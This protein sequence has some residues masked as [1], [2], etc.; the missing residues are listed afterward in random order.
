MLLIFFIG[1][2]T[3]YASFVTFKRP[4]LRKSSVGIH[5]L[6]L[7]LIS[8]Y[9]LF[10]LIMKMILILF[11]SLMNDITCKIISYMLSVSIRCSFWLTS[12]IAIQRVCYVLF[13]FT[14]LLKNPRLA[15]II[16]FT[17]LLIVAGMHVHELI[18]YMKDPSGQTA[19]VVNFPLKV[20][21]YDRI[22]VLLHYIIPFCIQIL[23]ITVL[24][25]LAARS[26]SRTT[27]NRDAFIKYLERQFQSQKELYIVP[28]VIIFS[29][30]PQ[31]ILSFSFACIQLNTWQQHALLIAYL[32]SYAPQLLGFIL[33]VLPSTNYIKEFQATNLSK[34]IIFRWIYLRKTTRQ[35][36][37]TT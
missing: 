36:K 17:T 23:S 24:I 29:G 20:I 12:W 14:T 2:V 21:T 33:F 7:S 26:R 37:T 28:T 6:A 22:T 13:P 35:Q 30:L 1:G 15:T 19:C 18:F 32:L 11:H 8:Q 4:N 16:N 10:L 31:A 5:L 34:T 3:N 27:K 25:I 9:S